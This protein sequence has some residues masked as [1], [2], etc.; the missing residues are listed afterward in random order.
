MS[1]GDIALALAAGCAATLSFTSRAQSALIGVM[2]AVA[3]LPPLVV[4]GMLIGAGEWDDAMGAFLLLVTNI[5]GINLASVMTFWVQGIHPVRWWEADKARKATTIAV[6]IWSTL[7]IVLM[8]VII[9]VVE[10]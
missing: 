1:L 2:V 9:F 10:Y 6:A 3:L 5:I 7:L 4:L 8:L